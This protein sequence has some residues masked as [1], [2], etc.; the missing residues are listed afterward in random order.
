M[1]LVNNKQFVPSFFVI[2]IFESRLRESTVEQKNKRTHY[3][4]LVHRKSNV[5][6][7]DW[8]RDPRKVGF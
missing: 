8:D 5:A 6:P 3:R 7:K 1:N 4:G 2:R